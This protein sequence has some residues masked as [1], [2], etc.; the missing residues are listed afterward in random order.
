[1]NR[2]N[3]LNDFVF[4]KV[5]GEKGNEPQLLSFLN[6]TLARTGRA[7]LSSVNILEDKDLPAEI[8]GGKAG[9]LDVLASV[10]ERGDQDTLVDVEVQ[11]KN[12]YNTEKRILYYWSRKY[13]WKFP[14]GED[15]MSLAP[16]IAINIVDY[17]LFPVKDFHTSYHLWEDR[18]K[19]F[20][21]TDACELHFLDMVKFRKLRA[22][23]L[24]VP[25]HRWMVY[26]DWRSP[27]ELVE[28]VVRMDNAI[29]LAQDKVEMI[30]RD[31]ELVRAYEKYEKAT[32]DWTSGMNGA[33]REGERAGERRGEY[34]NA[35]K[36]AR[37]LKSDGIPVEQIARWTGLSLADIAKL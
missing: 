27:L 26:F 24:G 34:N 12:Q 37:N 15:F 21:L 22:P 13:V 29:G 25:L 20:K 16:V 10:S 11:I 8:T 4:Q 7:N 33:R 36:V 3:M 35:I 9:K 18:H 2:L 17:G 14:S 31:P 28:E 5:M 23:D 30:M 1:M 32:S 19:D 6:A